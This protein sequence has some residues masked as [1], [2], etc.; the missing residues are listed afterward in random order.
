MTAVSFTGRVAVIT[1]GTRGIGRAIARRVGAA[2]ASLLICASTEGA[3]ERA[4]AELSA[5][6][7]HCAGMAC[8]VGDLTEV[9][10]LF[11][12]ALSL[13]GGVDFWVNNAGV[14]GPFGHTTDVAPEQWERVLR[15]NLLGCFYGC[16]TV[17]PHMIERG[18]GKIINLSGGGA[19]KAQRFLSAYSASKAAVVR[20]SDALA[21]EHAGHAGISINVL[22]PGIVATDLLERR[23][24]IGAEAAQA[25]S[26]LPWVLRTFGTSAEEAADLALHMLA[27]SNDGV[28][29]KIFSVMPRRRALYRVATSFWR[30][31]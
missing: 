2:G 23:E 19:S 8:D 24:V 29:G 22:E 7:L 15:V 17:L 5:E 9:E 28:S 3:A 21:R 4:A 26:Q 16:R 12:R 31:K 25:L 6:G 1:G 20:L 14:A 13:Y 30:A 27:P 18:Y 10:T 11:R